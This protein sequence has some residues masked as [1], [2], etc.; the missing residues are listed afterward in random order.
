MDPAACRSATMAGTVRSVMP[1]PALRSRIRDP[2][3][4]A[5]SARTCPCPV[6]SV[7]L[8]PLSSGTLIS[9]DH[10]PARESSRVKTREIFIVLLLTCHARGTILVVP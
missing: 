6:S 7:Q 4:R 2:G 3:L 9:P 10:N 5:I 8:P 1:A